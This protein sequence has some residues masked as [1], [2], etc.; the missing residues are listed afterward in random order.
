M[1]SVKGECY[2]LEIY[3]K[4]NFKIFG[5]NIWPRF[6]DMFYCNGLILSFSLMFRDK[7]YG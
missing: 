5:H 3:I 1:F 4:F 7:I 2:L 6:N